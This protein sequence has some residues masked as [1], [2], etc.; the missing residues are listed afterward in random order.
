MTCAN[1]K[2]FLESGKLLNA[3]ACA[4][5]L[6]EQVESLRAE[7][8]ALQKRIQA[9]DRLEK[10]VDEALLDTLDGPTAGDW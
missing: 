4:V 1:S 9:A 6:T 3:G 2:H 7:V 10:F 8:N 5:C